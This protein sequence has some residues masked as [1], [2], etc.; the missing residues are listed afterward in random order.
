MNDELGRVDIGEF[1]AD[2]KERLFHVGRLDADTEGLILL[3]NDGDLANR[4]PHPRYGVPKTYLAQIP[5]PVP[6][7]LGQAAARGHRARGRPGE[8]RH[9]QG[10]RLRAR[11]ASSRSCCTRVATTS[12]G[13]CSTRSATRCITPGAH[14]GRPDPARRPQA[15]Q[16]ARPDQHGGRLPDTPAAE[17]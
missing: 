4:L 14:A 9:V 3:T 8:G 1:V 2:R 10:G 11:Q 5:G 13:G 17:L 7:D 16:V 12:C 15:R 6:R